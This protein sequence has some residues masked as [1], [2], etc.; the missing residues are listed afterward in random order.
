MGN[1]ALDTLHIHQ[2]LQIVEL[3]FAKLTSYQNFGGNEELKKTSEDLYL[4]MLAH[5]M[6]NVRR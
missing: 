4:R 3:L 5:P 6:F 1:E 2:S